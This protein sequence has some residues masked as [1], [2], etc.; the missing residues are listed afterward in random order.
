MARRQKEVAFAEMMTSILQ[1][2]VMN[3]GTKSRIDCGNV[4]FSR[5][6]WCISV[7]TE[8]LA[9]RKERVKGEAKREMKIVS[10]S[11]RL[12][13]VVSHDE[14]GNPADT[15]TEKRRSWSDRKRLDEERNDWERRTEAA[16]GRA[17]RVGVEVKWW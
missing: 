7:I 8:A 12:R 2:C 6:L 11:L 3:R 9:R 1:S 15:K 16:K 17:R 14:G 10:E 5:G 4:A 13:I